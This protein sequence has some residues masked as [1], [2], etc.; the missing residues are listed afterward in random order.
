M[1]NG[2]TFFGLSN[3]VNIDKVCNLQQK[4]KVK[5]KMINA[6]IHNLILLFVWYIY[7]D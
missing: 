4:K 3:I 7:A 2:K 5:N 6:L 1:S